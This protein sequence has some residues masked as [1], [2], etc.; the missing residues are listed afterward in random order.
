MRSRGLLP[1]LNRKLQ[2]AACLSLDGSTVDFVSIWCRLYK[3]TG[4]SLFLTD[5]LSFNGGVGWAYGM[6]CFQGRSCEQ[7]D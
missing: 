7:I 2:R 4:E 3:A 1:G 5:A 6:S